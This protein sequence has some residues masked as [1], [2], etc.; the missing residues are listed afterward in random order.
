MTAFPID[1]LAPL[2]GTFSDRTGDIRIAIPIQPFQL[3][4]EGQL[5]SVDTAPAARLH[6]SSLN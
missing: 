6:R 5:V 1:L 2:L 4:V 3:E